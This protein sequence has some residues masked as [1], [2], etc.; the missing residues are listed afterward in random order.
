MFQWYRLK[1]VEFLPRFPAC[2][3]TWT[4]LGRNLEPLS[5]SPGLIC[6]GWVL[7]VQ[8]HGLLVAKDGQRLSKLPILEIT[9]RNNPHF[10]I[11]LL[12]LNVSQWCTWAHLWTICPKGSWLT[13]C[14][15]DAPKGTM[16]LVFVKFGNRPPH[17]NH[18]PARA[19]A[20]PDQSQPCP[21]CLRVGRFE[22]T[23]ASLCA[24][25]SIMG[26]LT[27]GRQLPLR[28]SRSHLAFQFS[29]SLFSPFFRTFVLWIYT[30]LLWKCTFV[31][32][33]KVDWCTLNTFVLWTYIFVLR[34]YTFV[35][36]KLYFCTSKAS[37]VLWKYTL[38]FQSMYNCVLRKY[39][40]KLQKYT[41]VRWKYTFVCWKYTFVLC[42]TAWAKK[43]W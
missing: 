16:G 26:M 6:H 31:I 40:F 11:N 5:H 33:L 3:N 36:L 14:F 2:S 28:S 1:M 34:T 22:T 24:L 43:R 30:L 4:C 13:L 37:F 21:H 39:T 41:F 35:L 15:F 25:T 42:H 27:K 32:T 12:R 8:S 23:A 29:C 17:T 38:Y 7:D 9:D 10:K 18:P 19:L 20:L